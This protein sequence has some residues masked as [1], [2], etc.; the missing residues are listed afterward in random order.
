MNARSFEEIQPLLTLKKGTPRSPFS[1]TEEEELFTPDDWA[2]QFLRLN[3]DYQDAFE[4]CRKADINGN[5]QTVTATVAQHLR[6]PV[7]NED[8]CRRHFGLSTWLSPSCHRLPGLKSGASWFFPLMKTL[9]LESSTGINLP[10]IERRYGYHGHVV[11]T[12]GPAQVFKPSK[13]SRG[14]RTLVKRFLVDCSVPVAAQMTSI[15]WLCRIYRDRDDSPISRFRKK[16]AASNDASSEESDCPTRRIPFETASEHAISDTS[17]DPSNSRMTADLSVPMSNWC[18]VEIDVHRS[19]QTQIDAYVSLLSQRHIQIKL[20]LGITGKSGSWPAS[21]KV[22]ISGRPPPGMRAP[23]D[24]HFLKAL[25]LTKQLSLLG[26]SANDIDSLF[27]APQRI[28][29]AID[30]SI[31]AD[32]AWDDWLRGRSKRIAKFLKQSNEVI[33]GGYRWLVHAQKP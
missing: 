2:W 33:D 31:A 13:P 28:P 1:L 9:L 26:Y 6:T 22:D 21:Y 19:V 20:A 3:S 18:T 29:S 5:F 12:S 30:K 32:D 17:I 25:V 15:G 24:G 11:R 8:F 4:N 14:M 27:P 23:S 10:N 16:P 7:A